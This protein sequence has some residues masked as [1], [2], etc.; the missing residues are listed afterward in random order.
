MIHLCDTCRLPIRS[1]G[2]LVSEKIIVNLFTTLIDAHFFTDSVQARVL[3]QMC[4]KDGQELSEVIML[5][6]T[7]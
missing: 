3:L 2:R 4:K 7:I 6:Y 5:L 1:Y